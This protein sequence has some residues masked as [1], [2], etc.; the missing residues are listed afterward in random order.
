MKQERQR[1]SEAERAD[2][3]VRWQQSGLTAREFADQEDLKV[4][5]D[6]AAVQVERC[7]GGERAHVLDGN[8]TA[9]HNKA[10]AEHCDLAALHRTTSQT[11]RD[12]EV[13]RA[14]G[15]AMKIATRVRSS[16]TQISEASASFARRRSRGKPR[17]RARQGRPS[18]SA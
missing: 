17:P 14:R 9:G 15:S 12:A 8:P 3:I 2:I 7:S 11:L 13:V 18:S 10:G 6:P 5:Y 1:R 4:P 16:T